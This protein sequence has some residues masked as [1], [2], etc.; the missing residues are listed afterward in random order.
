MLGAKRN[1]IQV[2][3]FNFSSKMHGAELATNVINT[4]LVRNKTFFDF[5]CMKS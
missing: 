2:S 4:G 3:T 1:K 5:N